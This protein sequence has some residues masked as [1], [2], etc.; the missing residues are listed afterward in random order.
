MTKPVVDISDCYTYADPMGRERLVGVVHNYPESHM[1][2]VGA[3]VN[4]CL[5]TTS[6][7]V[8]KTTDQIE[9]VRT[10]YRILSWADNGKTTT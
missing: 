10:I 3:V 8:A 4:G 1:Y 7:V 5:V 6:P 9:T 2:R